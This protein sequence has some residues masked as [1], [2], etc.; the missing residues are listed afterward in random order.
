[1]EDVILQPLASGES[2]LTPDERD[3]GVLLIDIGGGTTD[4]ALF[5]DG[6]VWHSAV[7][8]LG[9]D[10]ITNDIAV[11]LR[12]PA[13]DAEEL[14]KQFG[15][16]QASLVLEDE[17][18]EVPSIG[19]RKPRV[20]SRQTLARVIQARVEEIVTLVA[21][22][23]SQAGF[24]D[25]ATAGAVV[26]GGASILE[27]VPELAE[28]ILDL[29]VRRGIPKWVGGL[30]EQVENPAFAAAVGLVLTGARRDRPAPALPRGAGLEAWPGVSRATR[31]VREW[32]RE[33][34]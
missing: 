6:A 5:R 16:A 21:R 32:L 29:P 23:V 2:V 34:F 4:V 1:V 22:G 33:V 17:T 8:P 12:T 27:G 24:D 14:K 9:G 7:I 10:H 31:R 20:L 26:T 13:A 15:C 25:V 19:G 11:G 30:Y 3:L 18:V 28:T